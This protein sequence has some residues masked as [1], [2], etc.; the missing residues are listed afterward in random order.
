M[1]VSTAVEE[2]DS[3][4]SMLCKGEP[5][6]QKSRKGKLVEKRRTKWRLP[7]AASIVLKPAEAPAKSTLIEDRGGSVISHV[8]ND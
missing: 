6:Q 7:G 8:D 5:R 1:T 2:A 4:V 3:A